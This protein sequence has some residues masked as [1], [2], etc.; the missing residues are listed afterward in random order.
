[1]ADPYI[2]WALL[3]FGGALLLFVIEL[4]VPSGGLLGMCSAACAVA[5]VVCLFKVNTTAGVVGIIVTLAAI[6]VATAYGLKALPHTPFWQWVALKEPPRAAPTADA[7]EG[8]T[9]GSAEPARVGATGKAITDLRPVGTCVI[10]GR[11][12]DCLAEDD[13]ITAGTRVRVVAAD[14]MQ[15]KVREE[16]G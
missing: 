12:T 14:G 16:E 13:M 1:M 7:S 4:F 9:D 2:I 3:L 5:A 10:N 15:V 8:A 6:P 11:R